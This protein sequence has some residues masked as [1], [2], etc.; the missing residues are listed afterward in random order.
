MEAQA[1]TLMAYYDVHAEYSSPTHGHYTQPESRVK[2][3]PIH[4]QQTRRVSQSRR[5][6]DP[7]KAFACNVG[8]K[9]RTGGER[10]GDIV[11][12]E[13]VDVREGGVSS[14]PPYRQM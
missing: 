6:H 11:T 12:E 2:G 13:R 7:V 1:G 10:G 9:G 4:R 3:A 14:S 5:Q 8:R